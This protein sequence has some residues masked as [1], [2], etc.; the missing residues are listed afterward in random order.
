MNFIFLRFMEVWTQR[1][2]C[3]VNVRASLTLHMTH[4]VNASM[5]LRNEIY[6]LT[7]FW[8]LYFYKLQAVYGQKH[9]F[10]NSHSL[11]RSFLKSINI[12]TQFLNCGWM[13]MAINGRQKGLENGQKSGEKSKKSQG[14]LKWSGNPA[15][16]L[17]PRPVKYIGIIPSKMFRT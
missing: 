15:K 4:C 6:F 17:F 10:H 1:V 11:R 5:N 3:K 9:Y 12:C 14:I 8:N 13:R 16:G 2:P 7:G